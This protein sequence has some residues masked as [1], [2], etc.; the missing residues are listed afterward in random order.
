VAKGD[1]NHVVVALA[2]V[3]PVGQGPDIPSII[4]GITE[5]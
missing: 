1:P 2:T 3:A 4:V 5:L